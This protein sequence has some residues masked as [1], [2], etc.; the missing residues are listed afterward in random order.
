MLWSALNMRGRTS[1]L[2]RE[3]RYEEMSLQSMCERR[4]LYQMEMTFLTES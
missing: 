4:S 2:L 1:L 3:R